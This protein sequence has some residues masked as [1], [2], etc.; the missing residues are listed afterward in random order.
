MNF[1]QGKGQRRLPSLYKVRRPEVRYNLKM[2]RWPSPVEGAR[3]EIVCAERHRG[4]KS[5]SLRQLLIRVSFLEV[6]AFSFLAGVPV[7][8]V[9]SYFYSLYNKRVTTLL[10]VRRGEMAELVEGAR[11]E[12]E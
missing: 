5:H 11:L 4:F 9:E 1:K 6:Y 3:L 12:S 8:C 7:V 10:I 2:E